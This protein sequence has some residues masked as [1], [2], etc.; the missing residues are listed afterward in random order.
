MGSKSHPKMGF[1]KNIEKLMI[2]STPT[3]LWIELWLQRELDFH[4]LIRCLWQP[5]GSHFGGVL[6]AQMEAKAIKKP[7]QKNIKKIM[8]T[9]S[10]NWS[11]R[12]PHIGAEIVKNEVLEAPC[13]KGGFQVVSG[14]PPGLI[15]ERFWDHSG[16]MFVDLIFPT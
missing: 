15:L 6:G 2:F 1:Q 5:F 10:L 9:M 3:P 7:S 4:F 14:A 13:V 8:P 16:T 12:G 11:Q